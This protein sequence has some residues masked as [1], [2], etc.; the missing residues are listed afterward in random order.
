[1]LS[2]C[3]LVSCAV[4]AVL[5]FCCAL[6]VCNVC[7]P[8]CCSSPSF[9]FCNVV[10]FPSCG[11]FLFP[12]VVTC[13][14]CVLVRLVIDADLCF[15]HVF[16]SHCSDMCAWVFVVTCVFC[17]GLCLCLCLFMCLCV[18]NVEFT[19]RC[20]SLCMYLRVYMQMYVYVCLYVYVY[21][22]VHVNVC[23]Y[24]YG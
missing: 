12:S 14:S 3:S 11:S 16:V 9:A 15:S 4:V 22:Y 8:S 20:V 6:S 1:M 18:Y 2:V 7:F 5:L 23:V 24:L 13:P 17:E 21:V 19:R 10:L